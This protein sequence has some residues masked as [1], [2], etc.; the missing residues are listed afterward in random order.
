MW[1]IVFTKR[2]KKDL[3][4]LEKQV[5]KRIFFKLWKAAESPKQ[6]FS[7]V[8]TTDYHKL[9]IGDYRAIAVLEPKKKLINVRRVGHRR[10]I[11]KNI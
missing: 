7:E 6:S 8:V 5:A 3:F 4:R 10:N 11:Y 9:R 1:K 2:A